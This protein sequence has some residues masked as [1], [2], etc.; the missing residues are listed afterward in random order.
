MI[1][2]DVPVEN[3]KLVVSHSVENLL[4]SSHAQKMS[5]GVNQQ[6]PMRKSWL[7]RYFCFVYD[8]LESLT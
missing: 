5:A 8:E 4:K 3:I 2:G 7:I 6:T 1:V